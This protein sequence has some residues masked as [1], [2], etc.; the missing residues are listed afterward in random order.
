M[1]FAEGCIKADKIRN[2]QIRLDLNIFYINDKIE[3]NGKV[4]LTEW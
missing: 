4:L 1:E 2:E 3:D